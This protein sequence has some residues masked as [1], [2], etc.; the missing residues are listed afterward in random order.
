[1]RPNMNSE[2]KSTKL[3]PCSELWVRP[4]SCG[5]AVRSTLRFIVSVSLQGRETRRFRPCAELTVCQ[6]IP[7]LWNQPITHSHI[8]FS[9]SSTYVPTR[10]S[11]LF[12]LL[13]TPSLAPPPTT[14]NKRATGNHPEIEGRKLETPS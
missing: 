11:P 12:S 2:S 4:L 10:F 3:E 6:K 7:S 8:N 9:H 14:H 13:Q 5:A 1:M